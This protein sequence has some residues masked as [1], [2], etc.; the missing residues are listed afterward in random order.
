MVS[1]QRQQAYEEPLDFLEDLRGK[2]STRG[3]FVFRSIV[4]IDVPI[5]SRF[6]RGLS[7]ERER[8]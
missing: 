4:I 2:K 7:K 5:S 8:K 3:M 1:L 6:V